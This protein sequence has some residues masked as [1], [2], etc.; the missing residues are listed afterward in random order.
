VTQIDPALYHR[1]FPRPPGKMTGEWTPRYMCDFWTP[2]MLRAVAPDTKILVIL[3]DPVDRYLS[4]LSQYASDGYDIHPT[5]RLEHLARGLYWQHLQTL[6]E[7]FDR[8]RVLV[9]QYEKCVADI[10]G[11]A[12]RT[13]TFLGLAHGKWNYS[14]EL[15]LPVGITH[16]RKAISDGTR[17]ALRRAFRADISRLLADFPEVDARLW[18]TAS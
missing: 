16:P 8:E 5:S 13:F 11:E 6:L 3:R 12:V 7:S 15:K 10:Q 17:D 9:L 2:P 18:P 1:H 4:A 14:P